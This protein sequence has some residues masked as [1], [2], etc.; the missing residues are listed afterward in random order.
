MSFSVTTPFWKDIITRGGHGE[1]LFGFKTPEPLSKVP[2][3]SS[4]GYGVQ[5]RDFYNT[6]ALNETQPRTY[7]RLDGLLPG[8]LMPAYRE[9]APAK[10]TRDSGFIIGR[11]FGFT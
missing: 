10:K 9:L 2:F 5:T 1:P 3:V 4:A 7:K 6:T 11:S 8:E